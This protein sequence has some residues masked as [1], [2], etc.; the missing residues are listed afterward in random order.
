MRREEIRAYYD[1]NVK[2]D[3]P[4]AEMFCLILGPTAASEME[5]CSFSPDIANQFYHS[6]NVTTG[7]FEFDS[8]FQR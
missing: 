1:V 5:I 8:N 3:T 7:V 6:P 4:S 2:L